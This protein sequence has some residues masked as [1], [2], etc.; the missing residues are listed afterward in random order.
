MRMSAKCQKR[1]LAGPAQISVPEVGTVALSSE[2]QFAAPYLAIP[3]S[4]FSLPSLGWRL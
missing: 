1:T 4:A 2:S 3:P